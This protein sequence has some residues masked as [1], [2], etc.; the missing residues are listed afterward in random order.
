MRASGEEVP[1]G[2][3]D[4]DGAIYY[5]GFLNYVL[6]LRTLVDPAPRNDEPIDIRYDDD[7]RFPYSHGDINAILER[8]FTRAFEGRSGGLCCEIHKLWPL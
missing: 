6:G 3:L 5:K 2:P 1:L 7:W 4:A 8:D